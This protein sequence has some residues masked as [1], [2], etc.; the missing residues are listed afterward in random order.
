MFDRSCSIYSMSWPELKGVVRQPARVPDGNDASSFRSTSSS[1][2]YEVRVETS[3]PRFPPAFLAPTG[4][5]D[6]QEIPSPRLC[7]D[8]ATHF[9]AVQSREPDIEQHR[10]GTDLL[11]RLH[12]FQ[13][14]V[15]ATCP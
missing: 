10:I 4:Q 11:G 6:E 8:T 1:T 12:R 2:A 3:I 15:G 13:A 7:P 9:I 5:R 14:V